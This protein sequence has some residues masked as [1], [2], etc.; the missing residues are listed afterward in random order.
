MR[1]HRHAPCQLLP[2]GRGNRRRRSRNNDVRP[3]PARYAEVGSQRGVRGRK[4]I[5]A[6]TCRCHH[7]RHPAGHP[8]THGQVRR[9]GTHARHLCLHSAV[10]E[11]RRKHRRLPRIRGESARRRLQ[12]GGC[13]R[14][15]EPRPAHPAG[16]MG[17]GHRIR[18]HPAAGYTDVLRRPV[19]SLFRHT[20]RVQA[21]HAGTHH[22]LVQR[23]I[24][25]TVLPHGA[26]NPRTAHQTREG[27]FQHLYRTGIAG[28]DGRLLCRIPRAG[29]HPH[30]RR[31][32]PQ[33]RRI[34]GT[35][36]Q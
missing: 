26:A 3:A 9:N 25:K 7:P 1:P 11:C 5:P 17:S 15:T 27:H 29:R 28:H 19:G 35:G 23:Q 2:A 14:Y 8:N 30:H 36:N 33:H 34:P 16:R 22:R 24:R 10:S 20:R 4:R 12:S 6:D 31:T 21:Q 32:H 13:R 18:N